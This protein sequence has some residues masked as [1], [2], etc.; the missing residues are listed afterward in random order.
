[1]PLQKV[2]VLITGGG[3]GGHIYPGIA[4]ANAL[5]QQGVSVA[6]LG[7]KRG[8]EKD[9]VAKV[10]IPLELLSMKALRQGGLLARTQSLGYLLFSILKA[11][12]HIKKIQPKCVLA[13]GGYASVAGGL[14]AKLTGK[15]LLV[16]EQNAAAGMANKL[17]ARFAN[18]IML[19]F[20]GTFTTKNAVVVGNPVRQQIVD[21]P[22]PEQRFQNRQGPIRIL[23]LGGSLGA[24][25]FNQV[26]PP[27]LNKLGQQLEIDV[28]HIAGKDNAQAVTQSYQLNS[29]NTVDYC[30]DIE[31]ELAAAD[32]VIARAGA[33][34]VTELAHAGVASILIPIPTSVD[35]HQT[36]NANFLVH[37]KAAI[38][39]PQAEFKQEKLLQT[40][41]P[42]CQSRKTLHTMAQAAYEAR[43]Q[44][45][46]QTITT[47]IRN[48]L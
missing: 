10:G 38:L 29:V 3:T 39:L 20:P 12:K 22:S 2:D 25:I 47:M 37:K 41:K 8:L 18:K 1:M 16:L 44:Q 30:Y 43:M 32:L 45:S 33:M 9:L 13:L 24:R 15:P 48:T 21:L 28:T 36:K 19:G 7:G 4:I 40:L 14:A 6:W 46:I 31:K 34:T 11:R 26:I 27:T 17:L 42:L 35:D 23:V 5:K